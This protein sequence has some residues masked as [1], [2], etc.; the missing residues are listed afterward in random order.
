MRVVVL[1]HGGADL[2]I[3]RLARLQG[4]DVAA[5][6]M[7]RTVGGDR[8]PFEKLKRSLK[9]DGVRETLMKFIRRQNQSKTRPVPV[10]QTQS[11]A[12]EHGIPIFEVDNYHS[13]A[14]IELARSF[15]ADLGVIF[16][17]NII[18]ESVFAIPRQG[19]INLHQGLAPYY[20]GGPPIFWELFNDEK[21][22]GLTVHFV[23][24]TVDT[25][26]IVMQRKVPLEYDLTRGLDF[27]SFI[28]EFRTGLR[29]ASADILSEAVAAIAAG[30]HQRIPQDTSLGK[31][32][33][34]PTKREKDEL[35]KRLKDRIRKGKL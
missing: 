9:Y 16:G 20:R 27:E 33:R 34:L 25:G 10:D 19:S 13:Q 5:V 22:I 35:R 24:S 12:K 15:N 4:V 6:V 23:A 1:T 11:K 26:D 30:S 17:T 31:R 7:E 29:D 18:K 3:D 14:S 2:V 32:Y 8:S 21:E 28:A